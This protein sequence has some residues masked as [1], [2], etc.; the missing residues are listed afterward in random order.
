[1]F[2]PAKKSWQKAVQRW[3]TENTMTILDEVKVVKL[4]KQVNDEFI[5][6]QSIKNGFRVTGIHPLDVEAVMFERLYGSSSQVNSAIVPA[7]QANS[8]VVPALQVNSAVF[9]ALQ[10]NPAVVTASEFMNSLNEVEMNFLK[11][12]SPYVSEN[13]PSFAP[14]VQGFQFQLQGFKAATIMASLNMKKEETAERQLLK[15][16]KKKVQNISEEPPKK[17]GRQK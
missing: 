11:I 6:P 7:L 4:L 2:S 12:I 9:P 3:K 10:V 15:H 5:K 16:Q 8:A 14:I 13:H 17:R 1:M